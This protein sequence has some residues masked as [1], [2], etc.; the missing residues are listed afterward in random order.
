MFFFFISGFL[1]VLFLDI[2]NW[3]YVFGFHYCFYAIFRLK[4]PS[5]S[6]LTTP[7][8]PSEPSLAWLLRSSTLSALRSPR[9]ERLPEKRLRSIVFV[10]LVS[11]YFYIVNFLLIVL[12]FFPVLIFLRCVGSSRSATKLWRRRD[13]PPRRTR[14]PS[15]RRRTSRWK[16]P[17]ARVAVKPRAR[18]NGIFCEY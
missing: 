4:R 3:F 7:L 15:R 14:S 10:F 13:S 17:R 9:S 16:P 18:F 5:R 6:V 12:L 1:L 11:L 8:R 2:R